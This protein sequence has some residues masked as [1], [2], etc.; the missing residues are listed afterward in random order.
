MHSL[1]RVYITLFGM[2]F[3]EAKHVYVRLT[4][5]WVSFQLHIDIPMS[6]DGKPTLSGTMCFFIFLSLFDIHQ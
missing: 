3:R 6:E 1:I 2:L 5:C 4:F